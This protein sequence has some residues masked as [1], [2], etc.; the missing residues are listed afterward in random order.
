MEYLL[1]IDIGTSGTKSVV[2]DLDGRILGVAQEDY[3]IS[4]PEPG[5]AEQNPDDWVGAS[6]RTAS[7]ALDA[8]QVPPERVL[9]I[10]L[11]GQM[12]GTVPLDSSGRPLGPGII[13]ADQRSASQVEEIYRIVGRDRLARLTCNPVAPG[14]MAAT[15]L[16]MKESEPD[17]YSK[18][19]K[20][21]LPKD[22]VRY[23]MTGR[24][25]TDVSDASSTLLFDTAKRNW[26]EEMV[27]LLGMR[28]E[29]LPDSFESID[30]AGELTRE[31][32]GIMGLREGT[33]VV[34][35]GGDQP[36][37]AIGNGIVRPGIVSSTIGT[38]GQFF[39]PL[40][41]PTYDPKLRTH[42]FC[43]AIPGMW[44]IMGAHLCAGL[45][46]RWFR[47]NV[48][49]GGSSSGASSFEE[50]S[51]EASR[52]PPGSEGLIF[53][54]YLIGERTP[55]MDPDARGVLFGLTLRHT[56]AHI[57]RA[58][59]EGVAFALRDSFEIF[60][61]LGIRMERIVASGGGARSKLWKQIQA[62]IYK[63]PIYTTSAGEQAGVGAAIVA[64]VGVGAFSSVD[65][66][67]ER[68][69]DFEDEVV[70]PRDDNA[71]LYDR[72]YEVFK[73]LYAN[74]REAF[75]KLKA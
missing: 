69:I 60:K 19:N 17:L 62:D 1:G 50:L 37:Q 42:T 65:S 31:A 43:H 45:S 64:G 32:A 21:L 55:Y 20:V 75:R 44:N 14:F 12:H 57:V 26:S 24:M 35:G 27:R 59:M 54:P 34:Y 51:D 3:K 23:R 72:R 5:R 8:A 46:L 33:P 68:L 47:Q 6:F 16:W 53:L 49:G 30:V 18:I 2:I 63:M 41:Q 22:Y 52:I 74:N 7:R 56:R 10:G 9:G 15:L 36:M 29:I 28:R 40:V 67:C 71:S 73:E 48:A 39:T 4:T 25:G 61:S 66:A 13:W 11:S 58:I 38:G 70:M